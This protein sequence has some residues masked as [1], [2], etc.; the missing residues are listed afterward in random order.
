MN[1][2]NEVKKT[3]ASSLNYQKLFRYVIIGIIAVIALAI[4]ISVIGALIPDK[5]QDHGKN[6]V[7]AQLNE[8]GE[9]MFIFNGKKPVKLD[10]EITSDVA[11]LLVDYK[12]E[13]SFVRTASGE[14]HVITSKGVESVAEDVDDVALSA[15]GDLLIY[16]TDDGDL[17][18][19]EVSKA[20]KAKK[21]DS[22]VD[23]ISA[24][25]PDGSAFVYTQVSEGE[26]DEEDKTELFI[27]K[28]GK[29][30]EKFDKKDAEIFAISDGAKYVYY[31]NEK[32]YYVNDTKLADAEDSFEPGCLN[33]DGSQLIFTVAAVKDDEESETKT[34]FINKAKEKVSLAKE[35][36]YDVI[37][38]SGSFSSIGGIELY[39]VS[40]LTGCAIGIGDN[41][42]YLKN[43]KGDTEKIS[44]LKSASYITMLDDGETVLFIKNDSLRSL[45]V[46]KPS[47][48]ATEY[49][50]DEDISSFR[51]TPDGE[52]IYVRDTDSTLYYVKSEKKLK[53]I[54]DDVNSFT[55]VKGGKV[56]FMSDDNEAFYANKSDSVKKI[57]G[58]G[59][60]A[61]YFSYYQEADDLYVLSDE[62]YY[63]VSGK[64]AKSLFNVGE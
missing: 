17:Y 32:G 10:E 15:Y 43:K 61:S 46:T 38:P 31:E 64:K 18:V 40:S 2:E 14:L 34:Y 52:H 25:S 5:F 37:C 50:F 36:Y 3:S 16:L 55:V 11:E 6:Y 58:I 59:G 1:T 28:K 63:S 60:D 24:V 26:D 29:K 49:D 22:D 7:D 30:G 33:R 56:Y 27:S 8:D 23:D 19:G 35:S 45:N 39:N 4:V 44:D 48:N 41:Y 51:C 57:S 54:D 9:A 47:K 12:Q 21:I 20:D 13:Y 62:A 42:Y 53:K